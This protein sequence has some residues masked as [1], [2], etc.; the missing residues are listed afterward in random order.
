MNRHMYMLMIMRQWAMHL[1]REIDHSILLITEGKSM[2]WRHGLVRF[3]LIDPPT[4]TQYSVVPTL[5]ASDTNHY[6]ETKGR[7][8][9]FSILAGMS[10]IV[11]TSASGKL[12]SPTE[13]E[14]TA[15]SFWS[16][17][18]CVCERSLSHLWTWRGTH[19]SSAFKSF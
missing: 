17:P 4:Y 18:V 10:R 11:C 13:K 16:V 9:A 6:F 12:V 19:H 1:W 15:F 2:S 8:K 7:S 5:C 3:T 14:T